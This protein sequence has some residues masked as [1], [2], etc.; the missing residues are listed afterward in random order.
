M[1][2]EFDRLIEHLE[3]RRSEAADCLSDVAIES[4]AM[5]S[6]ETA[7]RE[8]ATAH[9]ANCLGCLQAYASVRSLLEAAA[10]EAAPP[11]AEVN[12][13]IR[14]PPWLRPID[15]ARRAFHYPV[16]AGWAVAAAIAVMTLV[17]ALSGVADRNRV[18]SGR[19]VRQMGDTGET[20]RITGTVEEIRDVTSAGTTVYTLHLLDS[21]GVRYAVLVWGPPTVAVGDHVSVEGVFMPSDPGGASFSGVASV[22]ERAK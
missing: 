17:W 8:R 1:S 19:S 9:L 13:V 18:P 5:G 4:L 16:P 6:L 2:D 10:G 7:E 15:A 22:V 14:H 11:E 3:E 21:R 20:A 12:G